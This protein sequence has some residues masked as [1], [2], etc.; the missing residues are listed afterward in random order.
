MA[1][2][3]AAP[4]VIKKLDVVQAKAL[5]ICSGAFRTTPIPALLIEMGEVPL[6]IKRY[7]LDENK[8]S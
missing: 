4:T 3:S 7:I 5:R 6:E 1:Y 2:G 8:R